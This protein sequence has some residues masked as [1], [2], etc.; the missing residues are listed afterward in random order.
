VVAVPVSNGTT[1]AGLYRGF[2]SLD[3]RGKTSRI[4]KLVAGSSFGKNP[5]V[6]AFLKKLAHCE[7]L[8]PDR[9]RQTEVNEPLIN[10]HSIDGDHALQAIRDSRGWAAFA[11]DKSLRAAARMVREQEG[12]SVLPASTAGLVALIERHRKSPLPP[13]RYVAVLT[14]RKA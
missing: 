10:W 2:L 13:D 8:R 4:P 3:R 5:I 1:L 11:S 6:Q 7:D 14:G 12:L 9:I